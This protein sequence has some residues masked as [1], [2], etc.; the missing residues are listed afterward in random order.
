MITRT[1][2]ATPALPHASG[3]IV[4]L[5]SITRAII[6]VIVLLLAGTLLGAFLGYVVVAGLHVAGVDDL[7]LA[8][9]DSLPLPG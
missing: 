2:A 6:V 5:R 4:V 3:T 7:D 8:G 1:P 9:L